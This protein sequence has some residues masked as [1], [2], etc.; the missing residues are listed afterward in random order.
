MNI[1]EQIKEYV[2]DECNKHKKNLK[3]VMIFGMNI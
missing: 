2:K 3:M 1:V